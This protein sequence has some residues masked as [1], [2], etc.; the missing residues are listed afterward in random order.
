MPSSSFAPLPGPEGVPVPTPSM[1]YASL[2][3]SML[4]SVLQ[5][6]GLDPAWYGLAQHLAERGDVSRYDRPRGSAHRRVTQDEALSL[7]VGLEELGV[8]IDAPSAQIEAWPNES[9]AL[10]WLSEPE[11]HAALVEEALETA[12]DPTHESARTRFR[13]QRD[14]IS[15]LA[16]WMP[17]GAR[18]WLRGWMEAAAYR[19]MP[20]GL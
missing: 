17:P 5:R 4:L 15:S 18:L 10:E 13:E 14:F 11:R 8:N 16:R 3:S 12:L 20:P 1:S 7:T 9:I 19:P 2:D 6:P